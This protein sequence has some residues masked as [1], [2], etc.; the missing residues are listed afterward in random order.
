MTEYLSLE[1]PATGG[2]GRQPPVQLAQRAEALTSLSVSSK[3][4]YRR[5]IIRVAPS[6]SFLVF[7]AIL[8]D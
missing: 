4:G 1:N 6:L 2:W 3:L 7:M 5:Q 8:Y